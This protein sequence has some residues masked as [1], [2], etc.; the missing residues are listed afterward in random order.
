M[1]HIPATIPASKA[2]VSQYLLRHV[3]SQEAQIVLSYNGPVDGD[4]L[5]RAV[6]LAVDAEPVLGCRF[7]DHW[8]RPFWQR[9]DDLDSIDLCSVV[10]SDDPAADVMKYFTTNY[11][12][13][14][15]PVIQLRVFRTPEG[16]SVCYK[17][18]H[19]VG[20]APSLMKAATVINDMYRQ[21][22]AGVEPKVEPNTG[23]RGHDLLIKHFSWSHRWRVLKGFFKTFLKAARGCFVLPKEAYGDSES[24]GIYV[25]KRVPRDVTD[26]VSRYGRRRSATITTVLLAAIYRAMRSRFP[27]SSEEAIGV[28][29]T[30]NHRNYLPKEF[31]E[32]APV[33][34]LSGPSRMFVN[35]PADAPFEEILNTISEQFRTMH[36]EQLLGLNYPAVILSLPTINLFTKL[37]PFSFMQNRFAKLFAKKKDTPNRVTGV[38]NT[39]DIDPELLGFDDLEMTDAWAAG[40]IYKRFGMGVIACRYRGKL[41]LSLGFTSS[42]LYRETAEQFLDDVVSQLEHVAELQRQ[43]S[44]A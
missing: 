24:D 7:F 44:K 16:D 43:P 1:S 31:R 26:A 14:I 36:S 33:S 11:D 28:G 4:R 8:Y 23:L 13:R 21:L 22:G 20:D 3:S 10:P 9:R 12:P 19:V 17:M 41:A 32:T 30:V 38:A 42:L 15:D 37:F 18:N 35:A 6:R 29:T 2:D 39:G 25:V 5:A 40:P 34:N 27:V